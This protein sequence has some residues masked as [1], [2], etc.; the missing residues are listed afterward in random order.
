MDIAD[1]E[2]PALRAA[3]R[4]YEDETN[5]IIPAEWWR[6]EAMLELFLVMQRYPPD[7]RRSEHLA[8]TP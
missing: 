2:D 6:S 1:V 3:A 5:R 4:R 7:R 8:K